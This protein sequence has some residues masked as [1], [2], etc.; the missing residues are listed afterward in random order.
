MLEENK[1]KKINKEIKEEKEN[2]KQNFKH[3]PVLLR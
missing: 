2:I 1:D 3:I